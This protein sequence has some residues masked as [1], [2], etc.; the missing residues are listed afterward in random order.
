MLA[1]GSQGSLNGARRL[2]MDDAQRTQMPDGCRG[3]ASP[4]ALQRR[5]DSFPPFPFRRFEVLYLVLTCSLLSRG[6]WALR[7]PP[8]LCA[9]IM[10]LIVRLLGDLSLWTRRCSSDFTTLG[11]GSMGTRLLG[12][13]IEVRLYDFCKQRFEFVMLPN[14]LS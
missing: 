4:E 11:P 1:A 2:L 6:R 14:P 10:S 7:P 13:G 8:R 3:N 12:F 9:G 5:R